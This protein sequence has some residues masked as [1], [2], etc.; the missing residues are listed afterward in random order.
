[1]GTVSGATVAGPA[2][3]TVGVDESG[4]VVL[5][6]TEGDEYKVPP[7]KEVRGIK[8][9]IQPLGQ[10]GVHPVHEQRHQLG[11]DDVGRHDRLPRPEAR[12]VVRQL[13]AGE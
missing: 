6:D 4:G 5:R 12:A 1:M 11:A 8:N 3:T 13:V 7:A 2:G 10:A 9:L